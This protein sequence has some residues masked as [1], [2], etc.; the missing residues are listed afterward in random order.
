LSSCGIRTK[1]QERKQGSLQMSGFLGQVLGGLMGGGQPGQQS[2][3]VGVLQQVLTTREGNASGLQGLL[4]RFEAAG[5]GN[6][7][8][9]WVGTGENKPVSSGQ[10]SQVFSEDEISG[11]ASQAGTTPEA[12][13][14]V[15]SQ[16]LPHVV[17][18]LTPGGQMPAQTTDI[19]GMLMNLLRSS[20]TT[21]QA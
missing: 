15:L 7:A 13:R 14:Q 2:P 12:M 19:S 18:H 21:R 5:L 1:L 20:G 16:A 17:D 4:T 8:Q 6:Q 11:W 3:I 10:I 9:S